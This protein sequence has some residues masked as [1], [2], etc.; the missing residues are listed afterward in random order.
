MV[1]DPHPFFEES[2]HASSFRPYRPWRRNCLTHPRR[3]LLTIPLLL[4][5]IGPLASCEE[6]DYEKRERIKKN[7]LGQ[8][9]IPEDSLSYGTQELSESAKD[10]LVNQML[11]NKYML[12]ASFMIVND[13]RYDIKDFQVSFSITAP[14]GTRIGSVTSDTIYEIIPANERRYFDRVDIGPIKVAK[15]EVTVEMG[16]FE[17]VSY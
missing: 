5:L 8:L 16:S 1:E 4:L 9:K 12:R 2:R 14:S 10:N 6:N 15:P 3:Q 11:S 13:S 17:V 7:V